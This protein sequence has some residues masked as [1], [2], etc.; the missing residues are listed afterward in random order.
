MGLQKKIVIE[1]VFKESR[2]KPQTKG[3]NYFKEVN[4]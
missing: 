2:K 1:G 4:L 3:H